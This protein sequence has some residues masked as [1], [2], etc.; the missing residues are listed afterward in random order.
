MIV[1]GFKA[2][3]VFGYLDFDISFN[4]DVSFLVGG[5]GSG[6]TTAL[7]L[8]NALINPNFK[9]LLQIPFKSCLLEVS[10]EKKI[11]LYLQRL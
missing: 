7:K 10:S 9:E 2:K 8:M 6:K 4:Q 11:L 5:N 3:S 1:K